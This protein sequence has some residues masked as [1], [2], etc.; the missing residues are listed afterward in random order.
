MSSGVAD[1][2]LL[3]GIMAVQNDFVRRD[4]L[5]EA[6]GAW[7]LDKSKTLGEILV[8]RGG[9]SSEH[10]ALL[11]SL[12]A[13]HV[14]L[15][16]DDPQQSLASVASA[17]SIRQQLSRIADADV[18]ASLAVVGSRAGSGDPA[19]TGGA[20]VGAGSSSVGAGS[21]EPA[22]DPDATTPEL[23]HFAGM[24][25]RILR[26][27]AKGGLGEVFVAEDV[28]LH[29]EVALKEIQ[30]V[31]AHDAVSRGRFLLEAE[32][33]GRLEHPGIVPVYGLGQYADGR[34]F[35]AMRFIHGD[36]LKEAIRRFHE[37]EKPGRDPGER[38]LALRRLLGRFVDVC[39]AVAYAH[40]RGVLHRDLKPGNIML[41]KYGE[42]LVVDWG[43]AKAG[44][45]SQESGASEQIDEQTLRPSSGSGVAA[46]QMGSAV[47]TPA[48]MSPEQ[49]AGQLDRLGPA[50]DIYSLGAT[51]YALL[52]GQAPFQ[53]G[54]IGDVFQ[55]VRNGDVR[56]PRRI[57]SDIPAPLE[58]VCLKALALQPENRYPSARALANDIEH[59]LADEPVAA[60][61]EPL[62]QRARRWAR[63]HKPVVAGAAA[64]VLTALL[65]G[66]GWSWW[67]KRDQTAREAARLQ[68]QAETQRDVTAAL[69]RAD[70]FLQEGWKQ[71]DYA[72]RWKATVGLAE[73]AVQNAEGLLAAG[74]PTQELS[75]RVRITRTAV[76]ESARDNRLRTE[77]D[78]IRFD[79]AREKAG[80]YHTAPGAAG[81][82]AALRSYEIDVTELREAVELIRSSRLREPLVAALEDWARIATEPTELQM[83]YGLLREVEPVP[84]AFRSRWR[85]ARERRDGPVLS[86]LAREAPVRELPPTALVNMAGDL[87]AAGEP[88]TAE[89]LLRAGQELHPNDFWLN[90]QLGI[91]LWERK[92]LDEAVR[93]LTAALALRSDSPAAYSDLGIALA[94]KNDLEGAIRCHRT[95]L[96]LDPKDALAHHNLASALYAKKE[97]E[98]A[99]ESWRAAIEIDP[100]LAIAH[101]D[102]GVVLQDKGDLEGAIRCQQT[103]IGLNPK[104]ASAHNNLGVVLHAKGDPDGALRCYQKAVELDA[105]YAAAHSNLGAILHEKNDLEGAMRCYSTAIKL[106][107]KNVVAHRNLGNT[108]RAKGNLEGAILSYR[109]ALNLDAKD[110][111]THGA[112]G[113]ALLAQGRF[114]EARAATQEALQLLQPENPLHAL[115]AQQLQTCEMLLALDTKLTKILKGGAKPAGVDEQLGLAKLCQEHKQ[116]NAAAAQFYADAFVAAPKRADD[117]GTQDRYNAACAAALAGCGQGEDAAKLDEKERSSLR[118][119][120]LSWLQADLTQYAQLADK[121]DKKVLAVVQERMQHRLEDPDFAGVRGDALAKLPEAE[122]QE[123]QK[124]WDDVEAL[125]KRA[126]EKR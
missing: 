8:E 104:L 46:T 88:A 36:N 100:S 99:I 68:R 95:A 43:L 107:P 39:N 117:L 115:A 59:W 23:G 121:S 1:L 93:F 118:R 51:L 110:A 55:K 97:V 109:T 77:L 72:E 40:S 94:D 42:T 126:A 57:N 113:E 105:K 86:Q 75:D 119:K 25:Y 54:E 30:P 79:M 16:H 26:P 66:G 124:L 120:A 24:R 34:P 85:T 91:V 53:E 10:H 103:A 108:L 2:N 12:V 67:Y 21:P 18:Q 19:L 13:A 125:S 11:T 62:P 63:R 60:Y 4:A 106:D 29:R 90:R 112:L 38:R 47:G 123:W 50:S 92:S 87:K 80:R 22:P 52:T 5:I 6:M 33:T 61:P 81:Y 17:S 83:L 82:A 48:F 122:R 41:G 9:L 74:E 96:E 116:L 58:A 70:T 111:K 114:A 14:R 56:P 49:A 35:Y 15:H 73:S 84:D 78:R 45:R 37:A 7:V 89:H 102:L 27:H 69:A 101:H 71:T 31:H 76:D 3:F 28:E 98:A 64:L 20:R 65:L 44:V 32:V